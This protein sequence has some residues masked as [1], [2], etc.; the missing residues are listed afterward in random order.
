MN[1]TQEQAALEQI[2]AYLCSMI[3]SDLQPF[4]GCDEWREK[5]YSTCHKSYRDCRLW[6]V[7]LTDED[8]EKLL[9]VFLDYYEDGTL[10]Y[11]GTF[12]V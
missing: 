6:E 4:T 7:T 10:R 9:A 2:P 12:D 3:P 11:W 5:V 1:Q 8:G